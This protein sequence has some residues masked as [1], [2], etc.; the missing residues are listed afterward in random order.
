MPNDLGVWNEY[1]A[2]AKRD[3]FFLANEVLGYDFQPDT[4]AELFACYTKYRD[5]VPWVEQDAV[6][7]RLVLWSRGHYKTTAI[8]VVAI[9]AILNFPNIRILL[10]QGNIKLTKTLLRQIKSHFTGGA[11]NSGLKELFPEFC[12]DA[13]DLGPDPSLQFITPART[14]NE[15]AQATVTVASP[16]SIKTGQHYDLGIFDDLV[17]DQNYRNPKMLE[18]VTDDFTLAQALIDPGCYRLVSGTRYAFGDLYENIIRWHA[19]SGNWIVTVKNCWSDDSQKL[20]DA[21]KKPRFPRFTKKNGEIGGFTT[22]ELLQMQAESS[23]TFAC[24]YLNQPVHSS[25]QAFTEEMWEAVK[26]AA[27]DAPPLSN[28]ILMI[29]LASSENEDADDRVIDAGKVDS[30]G[31]PYLVDQRGGKWPPVDF[32][33]NVIDMVVRHRPVRVC[34]ENTASAIYFAETLRLIAR[35]RGVYIPIE[36]IKVD[37]KPDAKNTR[38]LTL[39]GIVKRGRFKV[40]KGLPNFDKLVQQSTEFPKGRRGHDDYI[41][42]AALLFQELTKDCL[43]L[44]VRRAAATH[45]ILVIMQDRE[46]ALIKQMTQDELAAVAVPDSTGLD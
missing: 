38:V 28:S 25:Q 46:N 40:F 35:Q 31:I 27:H 26:V 1:R 32:A 30:L 44:P 19:A 5:G 21:E 39:A 11:S 9:Q 42:T 45:P 15:L 24:Q 2:R 4:H 8:V 22:A 7:N 16:R 43:A 37:N 33:Y 3:V 17:T 20:P 18:K 12:G 34:F 6:K 14:R 41:D 10:M 13:R 29:D 36:F 23:S